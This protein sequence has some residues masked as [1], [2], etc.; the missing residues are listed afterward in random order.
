MHP[1]NGT[2]PSEAVHHRPL[3]TTQLVLTFLKY[4]IYTTLDIAIVQCFD[5]LT[6]SIYNYGTSSTLNQIFIWLAIINS[7]YEF[8]FVVVSVVLCTVSVVGSACMIIMNLAQGS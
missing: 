5:S 8:V 3:R 2:A 1:Y 7:S 4:I 6:D